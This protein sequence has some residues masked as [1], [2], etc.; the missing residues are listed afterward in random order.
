MDILIER[1]FRLQQSIES[2]RALIEYDTPGVLDM[3]GFLYLCRK[4]T[5]VWHKKRNT[6]T[7]Q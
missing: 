5:L 4:L 3:P 2:I 6:T 7:T 1:S